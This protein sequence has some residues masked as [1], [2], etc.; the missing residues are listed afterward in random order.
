MADLKKYRHPVDPPRICVACHD[1][2]DELADRGIPC[3]DCPVCG[4][5]VCENCEAG[6]DPDTGQFACPQHANDPRAAHCTE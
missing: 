5:L 4:Y 3:G 6:Y 1:D 2:L